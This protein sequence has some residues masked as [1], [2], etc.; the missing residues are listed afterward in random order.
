MEIDRLSLRRESF[1]GA[2]RRSESRNMPRF[3]RIEVENM[4]SHDSSPDKT[5]DFFSHTIEI[6]AILRRLP[7][8][9]ENHLQRSRRRD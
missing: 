8:K 9:M 2:A 3:P 1:D 5:P 6:H 4:V 7:G